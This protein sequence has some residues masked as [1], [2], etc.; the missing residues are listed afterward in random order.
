MAVAQARWGTNTVQ[1]QH[2]VG[3]APLSTQKR[4]G[5][6]RAL[7]QQRAPRFSSKSLPTPQSQHPLPLST[8]LHHQVPLYVHKYVLLSLL[9][10]SSVPEKTTR[11]SMQSTAASSMGCPEPSQC[12]CPVLLTSLQGAHFPSCFMAPNCSTGLCLL[13]KKSC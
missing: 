5:C 13:K 8:L 4:L 1:T 6:N 11:R 7:S 3:A 2:Q 9:F 12:P 10:L